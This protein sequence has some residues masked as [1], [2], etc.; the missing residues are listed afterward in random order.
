MAKQV[1]ENTTHWKVVGVWLDPDEI[2]NMFLSHNISWNRDS[3]GLNISTSLLLHPNAV[4]RSFGI[5]N[6][7]G[8]SNT[9]L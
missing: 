1:M 2:G 8:H 7:R 4:A 5:C 6:A 9:Q 3:T